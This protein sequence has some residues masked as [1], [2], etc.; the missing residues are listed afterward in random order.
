MSRHSAHMTVMIKAAQKAARELIRDFG[1]VEHLQVSKKG[2]ADFVSAADIRAEQ[3]ILSVLKEARPDFGFVMEES[4]TIEGKVDSRFIID[5][6]DGTTNFL[7][8]LPHWAISIALEE[9]GEITHGLIFDPIKDEMFVAEK[10]KG[11]FIRR[12]RLR[13]S[14]RTDP[15]ACV[16]ATGAPRPT[17][18]KKERF[19]REYTAI[20]NLCPALR[21]NGAAALDL[22]YVAA[23]RF[24]GFWERDLKPWDIAAGILLVK[25]SG[26]YI[27]D[28]DKNSADPL[29]TGNILAATE[30]MLAPMQKALKAVAE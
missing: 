7:H 24:D 14:G 18:E 11:A 30:P 12:G 19:L 20:L 1:E 10:G 15:L 27:R 17:K 3:N 25:E 28:L 2:P 9:K 4:K 23:G 13:V 6:L 16:I 26:G 22:A 21:R 5:P 8:G 29:V